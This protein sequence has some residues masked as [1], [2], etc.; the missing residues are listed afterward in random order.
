[1]KIKTRWVLMTVLGALAIG[2]STVSLPQVNAA[3]STNI[4][5]KM[6]QKWGGTKGGRTYRL[7]I[8]KNHAKFFD[9]HWHTLRYK[10]INSH[11][12]ALVKKNVNGLT[13][14]YKNSNHLT[15]LYDT[16]KLTFTRWNRTKSFHGYRIE[17]IR[18]ALENTFY[19]ST[20]H[21]ILS[22]YRPTQKSKVIFI[23][24]SKVVPTHHEW[25]WMHG[26]K[27]TAYKYKRGAWHSIGVF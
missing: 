18:Y 3:A 5:S 2:L 16:L 27:Y 4:P 6:R 14:T 17:T 25:D 1:M 8:Y 19:D 15:V 10:K 9:G 26:D 23:K 12:Y 11:K 20:T 7:N 24:G 22:D 21:A 13:V